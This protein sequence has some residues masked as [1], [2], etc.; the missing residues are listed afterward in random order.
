MAAPT[1]S[2]PGASQ[3]GTWFS[4]FLREELAPYPGRGIVVARM[5]IAATIT[6]A[7]LVT[8]N[9]PGGAIG[10]V[11]AFI[12]SR[13]NQ[14]ATSYSARSF[15]IAIALGGLFIPVGARFF[16]AD[17]M[18][19][20]F[21]EATS[22]ILIFFL[23]RTLTSYVVTVGLSLISTSVLTIWYLPG[24]AEVNVERTLWTELSVLIGT[25]VTLAVE[26]IFHIVKRTDDVMDGIDLRLSLIQALMKRFEEGHRST[27]DLERRLSQYSIVGMGAIRRSIARTSEYASHRKLLSALSSLTG[28]SID[29]SAVLARTVTYISPAMRETAS[30]IEQQIANI[31]LELKSNAQPIAPAPQHEDESGSPLLAGLEGAISLIPSV[32]ASESSIDPHIQVLE[33]ESAPSRILVEDA[34]TNPDHLRFIA[35]GTMAGMFCYILY[36]SLAWPGIAT[37]VTTCVFTA[38]TNVGLSRQKQVLRMAG[39]T[40]GGVIFGLGAQVFVLPSIDSIGGFL[41]LFAAVT[42]VAAWVSTSSTRLSYAGLQIALA[43]YLVIF[44]KF[45]AQT[46]L[47]LARDRVVGILLG[48]LAMWFVYERLYPRP[49]ADEMVTIFTRNLRKIAKL[50]IESLQEAKPRAIVEVRMLRDQ[51]FHHFDEVIAQADAVPFETGPARAG[52]MAARDRIRR[53][54][55]ALKTFYLLEA[56][57]LQFR[58]FGVPVENSPGFIRLEEEF[59]RE[60]A[61]LLEQIAEN[62]EAQLSGRQPSP[63]SD[64]LR[65]L[66]ELCSSPESVGYSPREQELV[67]MIRTMIS[68]LERIRNEVT[69]VPLYSSE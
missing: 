9:I 3:F 46:S 45:S 23:L 36:V 37:S 40:I 20:F 53:W 32:L 15:L 42:S 66:L 44:D 58:F 60:S 68:I 49:A 69:G 43:F 54:Q 35:G 12:V 31:R 22:L 30:V 6:A 39:G 50:P 38:L 11:C 33:P 67:G 29:F 24:P 5:V 13:E 17:P 8:F 7:L 27:A 56:P 59:G 61:R 28:R 4:T 1:I 52:H 26:V 21:W 63:I 51:I 19:H 47:A 65:N 10:A 64:G 18:T 57:L 34:F 55:A 2:F 62:L 41:I 16:A 48:T 14:L 25:L